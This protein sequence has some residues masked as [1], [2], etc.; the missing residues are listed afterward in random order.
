MIPIVF[1]SGGAP[2]AEGLASVNGPVA[3]SP[4]MPDRASSSIPNDLSSYTRRC[5]ART[6]FALLVNLCS[7]RADI[8]IKQV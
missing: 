2:V 6:Y 5:R 4:G 8:Q 7:P 1:Q 3:I